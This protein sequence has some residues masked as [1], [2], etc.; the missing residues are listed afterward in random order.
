LTI[1][2]RS[3]VE[4][5]GSLMLLKSVCRSFTL[6]DDTAAKVLADLDFFAKQTA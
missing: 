6:P 3:G 2:E 1:D 4:H 5:I